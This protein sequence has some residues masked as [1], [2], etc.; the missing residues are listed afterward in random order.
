MNIYDIAAF[1][2][3]CRDMGLSLGDTDYDAAIERM[4]TFEPTD[5]KENTYE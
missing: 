4:K 5:R 2:T 1:L 3:L